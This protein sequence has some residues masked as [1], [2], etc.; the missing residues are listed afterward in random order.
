[1]T[2]TNPDAIFIAGRAYMYLAPVGTTEPTDLSTPMASPWSP[3]GLFTGD[4]L[5]FSTEPQ[6]EEVT[7]HQSDYPVRRFQTGDSATVSVDLQEWDEDN[8]VA[9]FGGGAVTEPSPGVFKYTA[10][11]LGSRSEVAV[12]IEA[13]DGTKKYRWVFPRC[14]QIEGVDISLNKT[15]EARLPLRL[16]V[17]GGDATAPF[18][19]LTNDPA[20]TPA[21]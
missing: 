5:S 14:L 17:L 18:Y 13:I 10:P 19:F 3:V 12:T 11:T 15:Q 6:F 4:S 9:V 8:L 20:V 1:M 7:S 21:S 16:A 2:T